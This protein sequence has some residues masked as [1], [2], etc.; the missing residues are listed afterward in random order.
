MQKT[1]VSDLKNNLSYYLRRVKEGESIVVLDRGD[2]IADIV[3]RRV[4]MSKGS[5]LLNRLEAKG[6]LKRG[7]PTK[8]K[9]FPYPKKLGESGVLK[10]LLEER[11]KGK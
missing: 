3:P 10:A 2:P 6:I 9:N 11:R 8:L 4:A 1:S 5:D 7:N